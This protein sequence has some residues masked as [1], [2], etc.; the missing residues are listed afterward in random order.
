V[1]LGS[2]TRTSW[3][4][5]GRAL[6]PHWQAQ[7]G[8]ARASHQQTEVK[9]LPIIGFTP[10]Y[11]LLLAI[12]GYYCNYWLLLAII[13]LQKVFLLLAIQVIEPLASS[14]TNYSNDYCDTV[15]AII[16]SAGNY[17]HYWQLSVIIDIILIIGVNLN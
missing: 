15:I 3:R 5:T 4:L 7:A 12:I 11:W 6:R 8:L 1:I 2:E 13:F 14:N 17:V 9:L 16:G 10:Y